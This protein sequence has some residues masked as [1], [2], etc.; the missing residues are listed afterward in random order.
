MIR[1]LRDIKKRAWLHWMLLTMPESALDELSETLPDVRKFWRERDA[2]TPP[3]QTSPVY[4]K[5]VGIVGLPRKA[6][7]IVIWDDLED[8]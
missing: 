8:E 1:V 5:V 4:S 6:E 7:P 3:V 2:Y